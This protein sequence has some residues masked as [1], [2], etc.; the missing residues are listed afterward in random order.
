LLG[1]DA[2]ADVGMTVRVLLA[3]DEAL[4][5]AGLR[6]APVASQEKSGMGEPHRP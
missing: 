4:V 2:G 1:P 6:G 5:R 3:D